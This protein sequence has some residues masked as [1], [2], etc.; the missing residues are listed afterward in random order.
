VPSAAAN[1]A[2]AAPDRYSSWSL[3]PGAREDLVHYMEREYQ[4]W[5]KVI[6]EAKIAAE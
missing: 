6:R 4:Q 1:Q 2:G 3:A 5:G